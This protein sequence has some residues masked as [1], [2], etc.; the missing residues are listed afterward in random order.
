M[1][2]CTIVE[3]LT[4]AE[5][6]EDMTT[7]EA[8]AQVMSNELKPPTPEECPEA[9]R[10]ILESCFAWDPTSRPQFSTLAE[11]LTVSAE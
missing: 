10:G 5:P 2:G 4:R 8:A 6:Y 3:M 9:M 1:F 11:E 7:L